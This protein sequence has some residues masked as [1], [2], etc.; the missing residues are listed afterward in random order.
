MKSSRP[1]SAHWRSSKRRTVVPRS[2]MRSKK[3][4]QAA[5]STSRP[6]GGGGSRPSRVSSAGSTQRRSSASGTYSATVAAMRSR[7]VASSSVSAQAG[8]PADHLAERP[9]GDALA[10]GRRAA[11][12]PV[13]VLDEAVD[14]LLELPGEAALADA[15]GPGDRDE[16][17][18]PLAADGVEAASL[19]RRNSSS[20]PTNGGSGMSDRPCPPRWA[21]TRRARQAGTGAGLALEE[22]LAGLLE[23]DRRRGGALRRLADE[24]GARRARPTGAAPRC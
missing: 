5:K 6:P 8:P 22:L 21:T 10:V 3:M 2:A 17:R 18:A 19:S 9:E 16:P 23:G 13:D 12:V 1:P 11:A 24:D 14:V 15:A 7:V 20:R 4:R